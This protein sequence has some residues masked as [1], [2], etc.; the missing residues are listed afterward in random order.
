M[1]ESLA[2]LLTLPPSVR[3]YPGHGADTTLAEE[4]PWLQGLLR[5]GELA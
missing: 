5:T 3:V 4:L 1:L 2:R